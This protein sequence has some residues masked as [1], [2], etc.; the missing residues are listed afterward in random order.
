MLNRGEFYGGAFWKCDSRK[1]KCTE[2][3]EKQ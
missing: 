1:K 3:I 2:W